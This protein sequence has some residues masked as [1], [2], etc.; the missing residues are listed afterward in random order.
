[1]R[2]G[3]ICFLLGKILIILGLTMLLPLITA[4]ICKEGDAPAFALS[5]VISC[6]CGGALMWAFRGSREQNLR[7][8]DSFLFV[9][10]V[11]VESALF[12]ALP[13]LIYGCL[14]DP[15]AALFESM[16]GFTTT[17]ATVITD[18][19]AL[20]HGILL[21]RS[22]THW[23]GGAGIVLLLISLVQKPSAT[24][25]GSM[26]FRAEFSGGA[27]AERV[28]ARAEDNAKAIFGVYIIMTLLAA[29]AL[30][31]CGM[32]PFDAINHALSI[33]ATGGF[34]SIGYY[35]SPLIE[36]VVAIFLLLF[37][38]NFTLY[39]LF[40]VRRRYKKALHDPELRLFLILVVFFVAIITFSLW[41]GFYTEYNALHSLRYSFFQTASLISSGGFVTADYDQWPS[42]AR[43][44]LFLLLIVGGCAGSTAGSVKTNRFYIAFAAVKRE[45]TAVFRPNTISTLHYNGKSV[46]SSVARSMTYYL[47]IYFAL[48]LGSALLLCAM[49]VDW[50]EAL[51]A[52]F[53]TIGNNGPAFGSF[54]PAGTF[55]SLCAGGK[56][57][58]SLLMLIGRLELYTVLVLL[59]P[60]L[61]R[62]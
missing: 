30:L 20:P 6:T 38:I 4:L 36:W 53:A 45:L 44:A 19:E 51:V 26:I 8:R 5:T 28:A 43:M 37:S 13:Y 18:I 15:A 10:M 3:R 41:R 11:W 49:G 14:A 27:L 46:S 25:E 50:I 62:K 57:L 61:W 52:A 35:N 1:M 9:T 59:V 60:A 12:G 16:S 40:F 23:L 17:G 29:L 48:A 56:L 42:L 22:L 2:T 33:A 54:G 32:S 47:Y 24:S 55:A 21:W 31:L 58:L 7:H 39:Y 34:S